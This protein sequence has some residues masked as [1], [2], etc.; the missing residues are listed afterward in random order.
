MEQADRAQP[1]LICSCQLDSTFNFVQKLKESSS[2]ARNPVRAL[3]LIQRPPHSVEQLD[4][5]A[6][7]KESVGGKR[8]QQ[9]SIL[10]KGMRRKINQVES[11]SKHLVTA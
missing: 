1:E 9:L 4:P 11:N 7:H 2:R 8:N 5:R 6:N 3:V 10:K